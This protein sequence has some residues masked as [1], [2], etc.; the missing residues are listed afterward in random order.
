MNPLAHIFLAHLLLIYICREGITEL[1][2]IISGLSAIVVDLDHLPMLRR[3]LRTHR[4]TPES[5]SRWHELYGLVVGM[6]VCLPLLAIWPW[7]GKPALIGLVSHYFLDMVSRPTRPFYPFS[8]QV[9]HLKLAPI[10]LRN[11]TIYDIIITSL[12]GGVWLWSLRGLGLL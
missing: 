5:R 7:L 9:V 4:F 8:D 12:M 3:A 1:S 6:I 11:L 10:G 2:L